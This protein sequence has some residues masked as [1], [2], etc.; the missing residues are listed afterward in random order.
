MTQYFDVDGKTPVNINVSND[1]RLFAQKAKEDI[2]DM[3]NCDI[4]IDNQA[5]T[6]GDIDIHEIDFNHN[7][8]FE[9]RTCSICDKEENTRTN[10]TETSKYDD[11][12]IS[13]Y[14]I[15]KTYF[16]DT[17]QKN[18]ILEISLNKDAFDSE[19]NFITYSFYDDSSRN[20][21]TLQDIGVDDKIDS[22]TY[23]VYGENGMIQEH[24]VESTGDNIFDKSQKNEKGVGLDYDYRFDSNG[25]IDT[26]TTQGHIG[27]CWLLANLISM[28]SNQKG[29][30]I[31]KN[32]VTKNE[33]DNSYDVYFKGIDK[34]INVSYEELKQAR[35]KNTYSKGDDDA[36]IFEIAFDKAIKIYSENKIFDKK[37][38]INGG[39]SKIFSD[40]FLGDDVLYFRNK[41]D[42]NKVFDDIENNPNDYFATLTFK[43]DGKVK[44]IQDENQRTVML[45]DEEA[46]A[47]SLK[48]VQGDNITMSNP[49]DTSYDIVVKRDNLIELL[50][51]ITYI[52][53]D[54]KE[55]L[56]SKTKRM[57][58]NFIG[59]VKDTFKSIFNFF[60]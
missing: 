57:F 28:S 47:L 7:S 10:F 16:S 43:Y 11:G 4:S 39:N 25:I 33:D 1:M 46:H 49:H 42:F 54:S 14:V 32:S 26:P 6:Y 35:N 29:Q 59:G 44:K 18:K 52:K 48:K 53:N 12:T 31:L 27:D 60:K 40:L 9:L 37:E 34:N 56:L 58:S 50:D 55:N 2:L 22:L 23:F 21:L 24:Y 30:E 15:E 38:D 3:Q 17:N 5:K 19:K 20:Y 45:V 41:D 13:N 8:F 51:D 36:L